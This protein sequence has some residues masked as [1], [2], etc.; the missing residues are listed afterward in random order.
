[1]SAYLSAGNEA[2]ALLAAVFDGPVPVAAAA[3]LAL[4]LLRAA[5]I[6]LRN[7]RPSLPQVPRYDHPAL[8]PLGPDW[9]DPTI[10]VPGL[11]LPPKRRTSGRGPSVGSVGDIAW[12]RTPLDGEV[13]MCDGRPV[14]W[15]DG[16]R[17][18]GWTRA[19]NG[20]RGVVAVYDEVHRSTA[21]ERP[22]YVRIAGEAD[23]G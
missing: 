5:V 2:L 13:R 20:R 4:G 9:D 11:G 8:D 16:D 3:L 17:P 23:G 15:C 7:T 1:M 14:G 10:R 22:R 21:P 12:T 6:D 18:V 19:L